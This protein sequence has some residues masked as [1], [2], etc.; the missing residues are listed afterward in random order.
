M[1]YWL[2]LYTN[3]LNDPKV[4]LLAP[5]HFKGW[6]NL[7]CLAKQYDGLLPDIRNIA[8]RLRITDAQAEELIETLKAR[9]LLDDHG[10]SQIAPHNWDK[11]QRRPCDLLRGDWSNIRLLVLER[12]DWQCQYCGETASA[13]DHI[14]ARSRGGRNEMDNLVATCKPCNSR[15]GNRT[16]EE[17][18]MRLLR[19]ATC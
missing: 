19:E 12:D 13:V 14:I 7:L 15:K 2:R 3:L 18:G 8:F 17:A 6:I 11:W 16:P 10:D 9:G 5:E 1:N 4:Q